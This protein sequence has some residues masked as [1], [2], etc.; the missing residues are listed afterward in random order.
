MCV[1]VVRPFANVV[2]LAVVAYHHCIISTAVTVACKLLPN[3]DHYIAGMDDMT[4]M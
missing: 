2:S 4:E 1:A 3:V